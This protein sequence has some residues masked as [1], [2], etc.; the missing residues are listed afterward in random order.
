VSVVELLFKDGRTVQRLFRETERRKGSPMPPECFRLWVLF[1]PWG[2][3]GEKI[4]T[5]NIPEGPEEKKGN[6]KSVNEDGI[7]KRQV[8]QQRAKR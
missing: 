1:G 3:G 2:A 4:S 5:W 7:H 6:E 8:R